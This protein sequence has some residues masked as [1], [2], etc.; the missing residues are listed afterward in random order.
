MHTSGFYFTAQVDIQTQVNAELR[1]FRTIN[2]GLD[3]D[4]VQGIINT[5]FY[6]IW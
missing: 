6:N 4:G 2:S 3:Y 5:L 1:S